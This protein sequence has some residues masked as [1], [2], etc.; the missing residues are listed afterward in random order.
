M[1]SLGQICGIVSIFK[2]VCSYS[3]L[4]TLLS[5]GALS[6]EKSAQ[7][8]PFGCLPTVEALNR[9]HAAIAPKLLAASRVHT[10]S[11]FMRLIHK[12]ISQFAVPVVWTSSDFILPEA[13]PASTVPPPQLNPS[14]NRI[15]LL[16]CLHLIL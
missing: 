3:L 9:V 5:G 4:F 2:M 8:L 7:D 6:K 12:L 13:A 1:L 10:L 11:D 15:H 14:I 16:V